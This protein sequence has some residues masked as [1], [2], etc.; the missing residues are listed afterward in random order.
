MRHMRQ[1]IQCRCITTVESMLFV[2]AALDGGRLES[3]LHGGRLLE[4][5]NL[6]KGPPQR[7]DSSQLATGKKLSS[8]AE[9]DLMLLSDL[10]QGSWCWKG[11]PDEHRNWTSLNQS[12]NQAP[13]NKTQSL[14]PGKRGRGMEEGRG[15][16]M[17]CV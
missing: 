14:K 13:C 2:T 11:G 7:Q 9:G 10:L 6:D 4:G 1:S 12:L 5:T 8:K 17:G 16:G 15:G 3:P